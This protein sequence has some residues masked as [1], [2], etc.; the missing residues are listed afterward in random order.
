MKVNELIE[1]LR[2]FD[3]EAE[4]VLS[5]QPNYPMEHAVAGI[6]DRATLRDAPQVS[7]IWHETVGA[8]PNDVILIEGR[9]LRYGDL[10]AWDAV[11]RR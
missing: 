6:T 2:S 1:L 5:T 10:A 3:G 11:R 8:A 9:W 7:Q 4:V